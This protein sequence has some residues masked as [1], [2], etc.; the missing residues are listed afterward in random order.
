MNI[1]ITGM[2]DKTTVNNVFRQI[3]NCPEDEEFIVVYIN[4]CGGEGE[5]D[6][7]IYEALKQS[8]KTI[9]THA[10][11]EVY[12]AAMT[13]YLA[14]DQRYAH[15]YSSFM[16]HEPYHDEVDS[17]KK[18]MATYKDNISELKKMTDSY[19][20][21][22]S[23]N[24]K[25]TPAKINSYIKKEKDGDWVFGTNLALTLGVVTDIGLPIIPTDIEWGVEFT[26]ENKPESKDEEEEPEGSEVEG[27]ARKRRPRR[28][29]SL[30]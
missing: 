4:S 19:F 27:H 28:R 1:F 15:R 18:T 24:T 14:G 6:Y 2:I 8:S 3:V 9:I 29:P 30:G 20:Q 13:I 17:D 21:L 10:V 12:S 25:L 23:E 16:I 11:Q 5:S 26:P 7:A 22:I